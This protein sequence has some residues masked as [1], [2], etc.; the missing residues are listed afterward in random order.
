MI[1]HTCQGILELGSILCLTLSVR[2]W[3]AVPDQRGIAEC[4]SL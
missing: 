4:C 1:V 2:G 3:V